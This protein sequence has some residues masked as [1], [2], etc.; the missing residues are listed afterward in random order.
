MIV[1]FVIL[2]FKTPFELVINKK[3]RGGMKFLIEIYDH[4]GAFFENHP[5]STGAVMAFILAILRLCFNQQKSFKSMIVDSLICAFISTGV[6]YLI[7]SIWVID[8]KIS[9]FIGSMCGYIGADNLRIIISQIINSKLET[10]TK[11]ENK[12]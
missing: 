4:V 6:T 1:A 8:P 7:T 3:L 11:K 2:T 10:L 5:N 9:I 12:E